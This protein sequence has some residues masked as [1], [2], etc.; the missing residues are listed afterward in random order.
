M[1]AAECAAA[2]L[3]VEDTKAAVEKLAPE[4]R[5]YGILNNLGY[6]VRGGRV[7]AWVRFVA[8][9]LHVTPIV[10][11]TTSGRIALSGFFFGKRNRVAKFARH[12]ARRLRQAGPINVGIGHAACLE[13]ARQLERALQNRIDNTQRVTTAELGAAL[14]VHGGPGTLVVATQPYALPDDFRR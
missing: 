12:V 10:R 11:T 8:E 14:G 6:A 7:P 2:G 13:D 9:L 1:F 5:T 4:T 3:S